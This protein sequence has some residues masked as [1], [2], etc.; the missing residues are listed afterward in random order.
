MKSLLGFTALIVIPSVFTAVPVRAQ[1]T[2][3]RF[4]VVNNQTGYDF[5]GRW[6]HLCDIRAALPKAS[7]AMMPKCL[8][9]NGVHGGATLYLDFGGHTLCTYMPSGPALPVEKIKV[10]K[11]GDGRCR[12]VHE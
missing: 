2:D 10:V 6:S 3:P 1:P 7:T 4:F 12:A 9:S 5:I 11:T 8:A